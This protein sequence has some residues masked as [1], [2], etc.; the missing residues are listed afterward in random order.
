MLYVK[1][2][3]SEL[4]NWLSVCI[5]LHSTVVTSSGWES[6]C[7]LF[8]LFKLS[9]ANVF[10]FPFRSHKSETT[11]QVSKDSVLWQWECVWVSRVIQD[12]MRAQERRRSKCSHTPICYSAFPEYLITVLLFY[13]NNCPSINIAF[14]IPIKAACTETY[15][16]CGSLCCIC[17]M[18]MGS[19]WVWSSVMLLAQARLH[20]A[21]WIVFSQFPE[22]LHTTKFLHG[23]GFFLWK[24]MQILHVHTHLY[25]IQISVY[26]SNELHTKFSFLP[27]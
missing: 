13:I 11:S 2:M 22:T 25:C 15:F 14:G 26:Q 10:F 3:D 4:S 8:L 7:M 16:Y 17:R 9:S 5:I 12:G 23:S 27:G 1:H 24:I 18:A 19:L 6:L 21:W 20:P